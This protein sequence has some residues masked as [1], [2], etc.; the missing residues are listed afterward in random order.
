MYYYSIIL[1]NLTTSRATIQRRRCIRDHSI[2]AHRLG[3]RHK[4]NTT[5]MSPLISTSIVFSQHHVLTVIGISQQSWLEHVKSTNH[6]LLEVRCYCEYRLCIS[7]RT[8]VTNWSNILDSC[9]C[10]NLRKLFN[11]IVTV[12]CIALFLT[13]RRNWTTFRNVRGIN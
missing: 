4:N 12:F 8:V 7:N 3:I 6:L 5:L 10:Q 9:S 13:G 2:E 1:L 11:N